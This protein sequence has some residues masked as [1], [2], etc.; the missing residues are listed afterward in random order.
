MAGSDRLLDTVIIVRYLNN[1]ASITQKM[2]GITVY[3]SAI[4]VGELYWGAYNSG[5]VQS[6]LATI[7][8]FIPT[9]T[10]LDCDSDTANWY[11]QIKRQLRVKGR[12]IPENDTWIAATAMQYG[13]VLATRD[14]HFNEVDKLTIEMW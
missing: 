4:T 1:D 8:N 11:G 6:N 13:L 2:A 14:A 10:V 3:V 9:V 12:P 5:Q 7:N